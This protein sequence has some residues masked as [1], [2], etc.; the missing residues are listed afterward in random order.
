MSIIDSFLTKIFGNK[1]DRDIKEVTPY[2]NAI[3]EEY[4]KLSS[5]S[6]DELR[7]KTLRLKKRI[8]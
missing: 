6:N 4:D 3:L 2:V 7:E 1:S 8:A 5:I